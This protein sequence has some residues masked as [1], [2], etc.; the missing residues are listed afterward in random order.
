M[1]GRLFIDAWCFNERKGM[2]MYMC[3]PFY[4]P[5]C[6]CTCTHT[7]VLS[8]SSVCVQLAVLSNCTAVLKYWRIRDFFFYR[9]N[10]Q[11]VSN[12]LSSPES[13][14]MLSW[15]WT[16]ERWYVDQRG[17][18]RGSQNS[19]STRGLRIDEK[20]SLLQSPLLLL[21]V[22]TREMRKHAHHQ[23]EPTSCPKGSLWA[24]A[25]NKCT[26]LLFFWQKPS[27]LTRVSAP[28]I[29]NTR[30]LMPQMHV[31]AHLHS[32]NPWWS[33]PSLYSHLSSNVTSSRTRYNPRPHTRTL[34]P[35]IKR[36]T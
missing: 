5:Q 1:K 11:L 30:T 35:L 8:T 19:V 20:D 9:I 10:F 34:D 2:H 28:R 33:K 36:N 21:K 26:W 14:M 32:S 24:S 15:P 25:T 13:V 27:E 18:R 6:S 16:M 23:E 22:R 31:H 29:M 7:L 3:K 17:I 12:V 4:L